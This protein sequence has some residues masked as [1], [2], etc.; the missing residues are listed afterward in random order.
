LTDIARAVAAAE[1]RAKV[2]RVMPLPVAR[3]VSTVGEGVARVTGRPPLIS[4]S[5][6]AFLER[7]SQPSGARARSELGWNPTPFRTGV[8][9]TLAHFR[10]QGWL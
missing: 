8:E 7:G 4:K 10:R 9:Q 6:L 5:V 1:P 3:T 2:P